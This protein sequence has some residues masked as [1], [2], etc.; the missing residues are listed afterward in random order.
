MNPQ[1][2]KTPTTRVPVRNQPAYTQRG[3]DFARI[4]RSAR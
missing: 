3:N 1:T 2:S 4:I